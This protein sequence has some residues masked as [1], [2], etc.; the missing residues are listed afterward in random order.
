MNP[1]ANVIEVTADNLHS[2]VLERSKSV[3]VLLDIWA[4]WCQ[5]CKM[6]MP[7]LMKLVES[8]QGKFVLAKL[9]AEDPD[10]QVQQ[11]AQ[12]LMMQL[13]V[14][15]IPALIFLHE[16]KPVQVLSGMQQE[17]DLRAILDQL[18]MSPAER[19]QAQ[20]EALVAEGQ[21]EQALQLLQQLLQEEPENMG[22]QVLQANLLLQLGRVADASQLL[23]ALPDD[24]PGI[25]QPKARLALLGL[26]GDI[27]DRASVDA[28]VAASEKDHEARYQLAI[29]QLLA[30]EA[31]LALENM[32]FIVRHDREFRED[33]A[34]TLMLKFFEQQG[35]ADPLVRRFRSRLF[36]LMH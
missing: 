30:D 20:V 3:P 14:R 19:V 10:P 29:H 31:E 24:A 2:E 7:I 9:N 28:Q 18:T 12:S 1:T 35:N 32:L 27:A 26:A 16:G 17:G 34:R 13:G 8:Y 33:G 6:L 25:A 36:A 11:I 15:S 23:D 4:D 22:L 21:P 5:P